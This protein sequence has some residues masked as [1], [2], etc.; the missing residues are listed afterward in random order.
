MSGREGAGGK[1]RIEAEGQWV[2]RRPFPPAVQLCARPHSA[3]SKASL[4]LRIAFMRLPGRRLEAERRKMR[5]KDKK[6]GA[7]GEPPKSRASLTVGGAGGRAAGGAPLLAGCQSAVQPV[8][9]L[10]L[11]PPGFGWL[12]TARRMLAARLHVGGA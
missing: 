12:R 2:G 11:L 6:S 10:L 8:A 7:G 1:A 5:E 9:M 3:C 4:E